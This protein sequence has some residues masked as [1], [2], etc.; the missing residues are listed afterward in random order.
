MKKI[1]VVGQTPP[2]FGGQAIMIENMLKAK[3]N[4]VRFYHV[5]MSF[6][7]DM[8]EVGK[9]NYSKIL[10]L[11]K[12]ILQ[13]YFYRIWHGI[14][15][16]YYPPAPPKRV[17]MIR[18]IIILNS[19]RWL[20]KS[21]V[22][23]FHAAGISEMHQHLSGFLK[24]L[25][26]RAYFYPDICIRLSIHN[27]EDGKF[28][29]TKTEC[30]IPNGL[31]DF[32]GPYSTTTRGNKIPVLLNVGM[33]SETKGVL[34]LLESAHILINKGYLFQ[35][36][37]MGRFESS[38]FQK[39][40]DDYI[41]QHKLQDFISFLGV[42]TG[43]K[44]YQTFARADIFCFPTFFE[45]ETFGLVALEAM[46]FGLPVVATKWRGVPSVVHHNRSGFVVPPRDASAF[47]EKLEILLNE[48]N[49]R[50]EMGKAGRAIYD[51]KFT[52]AIHFEQLENVFT[53][54]TN[55]H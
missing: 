20:F 41:V 32:A 44:K 16:L 6:S 51:E 21:V 39:K 28:L 46:Q 30:V 27:P 5:R 13:I 3:F 37:L 7:A 38:A 19:C 49:L 23:H 9:F 53:L 54:S 10:K 26:E 42:Q 14:N 31:D 35:L 12:L 40:A 55:T 25:Y 34:I 29:R 43:D 24:I 52:S 36:Q 17:P 48:P 22:F 33:L 4:S 8:H 2:P 45:A 18:D 1:L 50:M 11:L 47:A 15:T